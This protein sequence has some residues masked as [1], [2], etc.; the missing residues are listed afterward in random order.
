LPFIWDIQY[1]QVEQSSSWEEDE[2]QAEGQVGETAGIGFFRVH[3]YFL[4]L[5]VYF[6]FLALGER[7]GI[8][9]K[10]MRL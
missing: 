1:F 2:L 5:C 7:V 6:F 8:W 3:L 9:V 10:A 4:T